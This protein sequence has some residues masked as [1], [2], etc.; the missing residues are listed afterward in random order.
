MTNADVMPLKPHDI[1][2]F[3]YDTR[4]KI[5]CG[6]IHSLEPGSIKISSGNKRD[7][8][9]EIGRHS[10]DASICP[11]AKNAIVLRMPVHV[12]AERV[13]IKNI[14]ILS[15]QLWTESCQP[16]IIE[17]IVLL[18]ADEPNLSYE[19]IRF[20][21]D[22]FAEIALTGSFSSYSR[23]YPVEKLLRDSYRSSPDNNATKRR[24]RL[25]FLRG[26]C[27]CVYAVAYSAGQ[28]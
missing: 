2:I 17:S 20:R 15:A 21:E 26:G 8:V 13:Q 25:H 27:L 16:F 12:E 23:E 14:Q 24:Y 7:V 4:M 28:K 11:P 18:F 3:G 10:H 19:Q 6:T 1:G 9:I 5:K 22:T